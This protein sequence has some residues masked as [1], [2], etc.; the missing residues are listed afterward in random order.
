MF[1]SIYTCFPPLSM[2]GADDPDFSVDLTWS[3]AKIHT[4]EILYIICR[5]CYTSQGDPDSSFPYLCLGDRLTVIPVFCYG[6]AVWYGYFFWTGFT[7]KSCCWH[8]VH[9]LKFIFC[10]WANWEMDTK[11]LCVLIR[12]NKH[13]QIGMLDT[14]NEALLSKL[15]TSDH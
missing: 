15:L 1:A 13:E 10:P 5:N 2:T 14:S 11:N 4:P 6:E 12:A 3:M 8:S 9:T 7:A